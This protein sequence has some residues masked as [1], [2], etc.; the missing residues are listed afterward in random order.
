MIMTIEM[1]MMMMMT[2]MMY[3][4]DDDSDVGRYEWYGDKMTGYDNLPLY[5]FLLR[6]LR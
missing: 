4:D 1:M 6:V 3:D 5:S 2:M